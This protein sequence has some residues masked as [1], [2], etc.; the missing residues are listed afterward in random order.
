M[1][2]HCGYREMVFALLCV[3]MFSL[4]QPT[5]NLFVLFRLS[6]SLSPEQEQGLWKQRL[7][8]GQPSQ[9]QFTTKQHH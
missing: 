2:N 5:Y 7:D 3:I 6:G 4:F 9:F 1:L 8:V